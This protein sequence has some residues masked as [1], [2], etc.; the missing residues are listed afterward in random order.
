MNRLEALKIAKIAYNELNDVVEKWNTGI[1]NYLP[2]TFHYTGDVRVG[3]HFF[4]EYELV[5]TSEY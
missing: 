5:E 2:I 4:Y 1:I 3:E